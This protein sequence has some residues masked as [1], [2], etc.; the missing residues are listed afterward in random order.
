MTFSIDKERFLRIAEELGLEIEFGSD[1][2][3]VTNKRTG[4]TVTF[5]ACLEWLYGTTDKEGDDN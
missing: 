1:S 3:G 4:E 2:P 5:G